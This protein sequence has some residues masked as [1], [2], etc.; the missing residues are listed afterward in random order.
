MRKSAVAEL[1]PRRPSGRRTGRSATR[2]A[3]LTAAR[4]QF[5]E[6]GYDRASLR[7]IAGEASVDQ[8]LVAYFFGSKHALFVTATHL[9]F[10]VGAMI[11]HVLGGAQ[12][13]R[14]TRLAR[15][16]VEMLDNPETGPRLIGLVRAA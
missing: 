16:L 2:D 4:R 13:E 10:D 1:S 5:A 11:A 8:K 15:R 9:P 3:V 14:G 6:F 7:S 12:T